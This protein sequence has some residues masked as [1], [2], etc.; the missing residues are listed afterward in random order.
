MLYFINI[1]LTFY[2]TG[3]EKKSKSNIYP[4]DCMFSV[5]DIKCFLHFFFQNYFL[6]WYECMDQ[7]YRTI[8]LTIFTSIKFL[9]I[10]QFWSNIISWRKFWPVPFSNLI[11]KSYYHMSFFIIIF[12]CYLARECKPL[13]DVLPLLGQ[14][15]VERQLDNFVNIFFSSYSKCDNN[16][17]TSL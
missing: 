15:I 10:F 6:C 13:L 7:V 11:F 1:L 14:Y 3:M 12:G 4:H 8:S 9:F 16:P 2:D 17:Q 5:S